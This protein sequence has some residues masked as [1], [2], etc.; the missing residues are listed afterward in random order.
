NP[1]LFGWSLDRRSIGRAHLQRFHRWVDSRM[2]CADRR[3]FPTLRFKRI[4]KDPA[5]ATRRPRLLLS[6]L[7]L[8][9]NLLAHPG[10]SF[11]AS[12]PLCLPDLGCGDPPQ[13]PGRRI[14]DRAAG[15]GSRPSAGVAVYR[16]EFPGWTKRVPNRVA[17]WCVTP[18]SRE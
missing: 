9:A 8:S 14:L 5:S 7:A 11:A 12:V 16:L 4:C 13:L 18:L 15:A 1:F 10:P 3:G 17:A 2:A 6:E